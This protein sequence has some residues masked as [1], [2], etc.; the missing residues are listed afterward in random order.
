[1]S[2]NSEQKVVL[3]ISEQLIQYTVLEIHFRPLKYTYITDVRIGKNLS[4]FPVLF[5]R[6]TILGDLQCVDLNNPIQTVWKRVYTV[7]T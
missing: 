1:M 3:Q 6:Q 4:N 5:K 7:S 2:G